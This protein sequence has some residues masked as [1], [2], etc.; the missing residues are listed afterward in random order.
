MQFFKVISDQLK[1]DHFPY[2]DGTHKHPHDQP[3][4][5]SFQLFEDTS[6]VEF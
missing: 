4:K 6:E 3:Q 2:C 1:N 5:Q